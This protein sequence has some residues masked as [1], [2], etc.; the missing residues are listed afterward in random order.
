MIPEP[1]PAGTVRTKTNRAKLE[2]GRGATIG[3]LVLE[4]E[5]GPVVGHEHGVEQI[6]GDKG[7]YG[8]YRD[9]A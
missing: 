4:N 1:K 2:P 8:R 7:N 9:L 6:Y 3:K 5:A